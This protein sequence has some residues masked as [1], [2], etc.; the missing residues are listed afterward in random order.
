MYMNGINMK[1]WATT[2][3][4]TAL[5]WGVAI[6]MFFPV[7]W[8]L[9]TGFK[10]ELQAVTTPPI[11]VFE[12]T[13]EG[14]REVFSRA[15]YASFA[16]NSVAVSLGSTA[17]AMALA[18]P[19][20]YAM[21]FYPTPRTRGAL[22]WMLSTKMLPPVGALAPIY[23]IFR[24]LGILDTVFGLSIIYALINLPI[25][26]WMLFGFFK[27][28]PRD[29][30][31]AARIDGA[32]RVQEILLALLPLSMPGLAST[33]LLSIILSWNESFWSIILTTTDAAPLPVFIAS[34][35]SPEGLF[36]A[37][38]S[39]AAT[40]AVAPILIFGWLAQRQL[41]RGLTFGAVK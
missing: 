20:A 12:P 29:I 41:V 9:V 40:L 4:I 8:M 37:K 1:K 18:I 2:A 11:W 5:A 14:Y 6:V 34:F 16:L 22:L 23:F 13:L 7:F 30:L 3:G 24:D 19:A 32:G 36:W 28:I 35:S 38:L 39:A 10:T 26:V 31:E 33:A 17:L 15:D 21:A 25:V 27:D